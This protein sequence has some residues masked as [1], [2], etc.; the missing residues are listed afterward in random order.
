MNKTNPIKFGTDGWRAVIAREFTFD[1]V[2]ICAQALAEYLQETGLAKNGLVIGYDTRFASEDFASACAEVAAANG[3]KVYLST[4]AIPTPEVSYAITLKKAGAG[5]VI[6]ASHNPGSYNGFKIKSADGASA[7]TEMIENIEKRI[8]RIFEI[9]DVKRFMLAEGIAKGLVERCDFDQPYL[10]RVASFVDLNRIQQS[11]LKIVVDSMHGAGSG[12]FKTLLSGGKVNL[13]EINSERNPIFPGINPEPIA[14]NLKK[15]STKMLQDEASVGLATDGDADRIG[16]VDEKGRFVTQLEVYA[17]LALYWLEVRGE[18][19][20]IVKTVT[21]TSMLYRLG[22]LFKVPVI[23]TPVGFK[24]VAPVMMEQNALIGGEES[25]GYGFRGH[26]PERDA[27]LAGL[28]FLDLMVATGKSPAQLLDYLFSKV[29]I[30][31]YN[32]RDFYFP[33]EQ[34][35]DIIDN[36]QR[37]KPMIIDRQKVVRFDTVDGFRFT[38]E[39][40]SWLLV[41]FSGTEP[42]LRIYSESH[43]HAQV[44]NILDFGQQ[45]TG[46]K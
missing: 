41:R 10:Q 39:D 26:V 22:E 16:I 43:S 17:L 7:P 29:G 27:V 4:K 30:H 35:A 20:A 2:C 28:C 34:R 23:E 36:L 33:E 12:Y 5:V 46:V 40:N 15:L 13:E 25:G 42:L 31:Y 45:L 14:V 1:N 24:Y 32:R 37:K 9:G 8:S 11:N 18:R 6:T 38:L 44:E 19:G 21:A 3:I